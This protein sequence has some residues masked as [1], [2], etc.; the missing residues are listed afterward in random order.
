MI[1][2]ID[3]V[4]QRD[5]I[6]A[7]EDLP[8]LRERLRDKRIIQC[9]GAFDLVHIGHLTHFEEAR[10]LGDVLVV[11]ITAD[12][13]ITK[14]RA[15]TFTISPRQ[16]SLIDDGGKRVIE[17]GEFLVSA[18]GGQPGRQTP[19]VTGKFSVSGSIELPER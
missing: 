10:A 16:M 19:V 17:P 7:A 15:V 14:K 2:T 9:H 13:H 6:V 18:G 12:S 5:K 11:T 8:R 1:G 3:G 4:S